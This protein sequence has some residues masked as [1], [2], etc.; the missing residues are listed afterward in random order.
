MS[1][2]QNMKPLKELNLTDRFLFDEVMEDPQVH[3]DVLSIIFGREIPLLEKNETEK[4]I[5]VSPVIRSIRMDVFAMDADQ[6]VYNTEMQAQKRNDLA[7]RSRYYQ[8]L[9][10]TSLL[11]PGIPDYNLLNQ[12]YIIMIT[13]FDLFGYGRYRYT[14]RARCEEEPECV[15]ED[16]ATRIFLNTRG[17][18]AHKVSKELVEFLHYAEHTTDE[19][20]EETESERIRRIHDRVCKVKAS[21][22]VGVKYM[23]A[24]EERY[25]ELEEAKEEA[26]EEG[27]EE[28]RDEGARVKLKELVI[29]KLNKGKTAEEIADILEE[30]LGTIEKIIEELN[31]K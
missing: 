13:S 21:E 1:K 23:Q 29:K 8:S 11:E 14:F 9:V 30:D 2:K 27:R 16:G 20:A 26:R 25:Y 17:K 15:L 12:S 18:N 19:T 4:E 24:W 10:D 6:A 31:T 5:R 28:G 3:Q 7:K 22:Q